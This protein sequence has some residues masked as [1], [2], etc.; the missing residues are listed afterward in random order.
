VCEHMATDIAPYDLW[1]QDGLLTVTGG[2][3]DFKN[4]YKFILKHLNDLKEEYKL[5]FA[6]IG[7]DPHNADGILA[8]L[9]EYGCPVILVVQSAKNLNDATQDIMLLVKGGQYKYHRSSDLL[10]WCAANSKLVYN[11]FGECKVDKRYGRFK[12]IDPIDACIDAHW[13]RLTLKQNEV[14][15]TN[16]AL[17]DYLKVMGWRKEA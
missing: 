10:S 13:C 15:D 6:G 1:E 5:S 9:E 16:A 3:S 2:E 7:I 17:E 12:R 14:I 11:S 8:D 4:D